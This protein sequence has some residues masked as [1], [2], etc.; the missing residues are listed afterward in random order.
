MADAV[1]QPDASA[2][3]LSEIARVIDTFSAPS[4][5]FTDVKRSA[6]WWLPFLIGAVVTIVTGACHSAEDRLG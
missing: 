4:K 6:S 2:A 3:P 5:T 1:A